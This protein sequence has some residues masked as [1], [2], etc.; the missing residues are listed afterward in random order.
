MPLLHSGPWQKTIILLLLDLFGLCIVFS[1]NNYTFFKTLLVIS[2]IYIFY[3]FYK[4][5]KKEVTKTVITS[6]DEKA[7]KNVDEELQ[8]GDILNNEDKEQINRDLEYKILQDKYEKKE[9]RFIRFYNNKKGKN[10]EFKDQFDFIN[11]VYIFFNIVILLI[12]IMVK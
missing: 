2:Y 7:Y 5:S 9:N 1:L 8:N 3:L 12:V 11:F 10:I 6:D 4:T